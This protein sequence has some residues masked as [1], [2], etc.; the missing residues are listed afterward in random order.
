MRTTF[1]QLLY[2]CLLLCLSSSAVNGQLFINEFMASNGTTLADEAGDFDD[3]IEIYNAGSSAVDL[4]GYYISDAVTN[5]LQ[6]QIPTTNPTLTTV[7]AGGYLLLWADK[8]PTQGPHHINIKLGSGGED[9]VLTAPDGSTVVDQYTYTTQTEDISFGRTSDGGSNWDFFAEPTPDAANTTTPGAPQVEA[10]SISVAGGFKTGSVQVDLA[11]TTSGATIYYTLDGSKPTENSSEYT[12]TISISSSAPLRARAFLAPL[13]PSDITTETYLFNVNHTVPVVAYTADPFD[14]YDPSV[15]MFTN[16]EQDIE[17]NVNAELYE[18]DGTQGFNQRFESEI[19]GTGSASLPQK[20]LVLK[21]KSSLGSST[22]DYQVFPKSSRDKYRSLTLRNSGQDWNITMFRDAM[23]TSLIWDVDDVNATNKTIVKPEIF[24][25]AYRPG[26]T[27]LNGEYW[28]LLNIRE[29]SD[30]RYIRVHFGLDDNEIDF[31]ENLNEV[32][33]GDLTAWTELKDYLRN[34]NLSSESNFRYV[35][36]RVD[37]KHY[38][39]YVTF[40]IYIDNS[41]WPSNN[42]RRFRERVPEGQWRWLTFDLDFSFGLFVDGQ[43]WNSGYNDANSLNRLLT[44]NGFSWPNTESSTLLFRKLME[45]EDWRTNF[46]NRMADQLNVLFNDSRVVGRIN[47]FQADYAPEIQQH[48]DKWASGFQKFDEN[49]QKLRTF[50]NGRADNVRNHFVSEISDITGTS[51][52]T[53]NLNSAGQ[54]E[55]E[56]STISIHQNNAPFTGTYFDG[57]DIPVRAYPNR[58][59]VLQSWSGGLSGNNPTASINISSNTSIT[60]NFGPGSFAQDPIVINEINYNSADFL[61]SDDWVELYNPNNSA[62]DISGWYFE[63]EGGDYFSIPANTILPADGYLV[64]VENA[65]KFTTIYPQVTNYIGDFGSKNSAR[66]FGL[67]GGGERITLK[68][69]GGVLIDE[70]E[71]DDKSPWPTNAD[72]NGPTLQLIAPNLDNALAAS[73]NGIPATPGA[74]NG[75]NTGLNQTINFPAIADKQ[76]TSGPFQISAT[77]TS[78]LPVSFAIVSGPASIS[79]DQITLNGTPGTV[80]VR[81]SQSGD[82]NWN[83]A[84]VVNQSFNVVLVTGGGNY[85]GSK[86]DMPWVEWIAGVELNNLNH[87]SGKTQ[88]SDFTSQFASVDQGATYPITLSAGYSYTA[89][90]EY[91]RVWI[92]Y[93]QDNV[94]DSNTELAYAGVLSGVNDGAGGGS[95]SGS[96]S[97]PGNALTG[98]TRMRVSMQRGAYADPCENFVN[99]EVEDYSIFINSGNN[100][101]VL[102]LSNCPADV[103]ET[104]APGQNSATVSW[105]APSASTTCDPN[106]VSLTQTA[107]PASGSSFTAGTTTTIEYTA[108]D[109]CGNQEVCS[110]TVTVNAPNN[111]SITLSCPSDITATAAAG[112]NGATVNWSDATAS[113]TCPNGGLSVSQTGGAASG[114]FFQ[115]GTYQITYTATDACGNQET[116]SFTVTVNAP[117]NGSITLSCPSDIT[118]AAAAGQNGATVNWSDATASTTC[119]SGGLSVSQT[120]GAASGTFFQVGTYQITYTATDACGNQENCSFSVTVTGGNNNSYCASKGNAPWLEYIA[121]VELSDL[122][123]TSGKSQYSDYTSQIAALSKGA[124]YP[125]TLTAG[126][127]WTSYDEYFRVWIDYNQNGVFEEPSEIAYSGILSGIPNGTGSG[128]LVGSIAVPGSALN[129]TTRMR[130]SMQRDAYASPCETFPTGEVED[131]NVHINGTGNTAVL[132]L[133]NCPNNISLTANQG[134]TSA[135]ATWVSPNATTT[136]DPNTVT[137][138]RTSGPSSGSAF[139]VNTTTTIEYTAT[140]ECGNQEI[141]SF[142]VTVTPSVPNNGEYC[143]AEGITPWLDYIKGVELSSLNNPSGKSKYSDFTNLSTALVPSNTYDL[144]LTTGY[145]WTT[146]DEYWNVWIDYNQNGI[147]ETPAELAFSG[148]QNRPANGTKTAILN[149]QITVPASASLGSTR[150]RVAMKRGAA[151]DPCEAFANGEV[152]DYTIVLTSNFNGNTPQFSIRPQIKMELFPNPSADEVTIIL[153]NDMEIEQIEIFD[154]ST[155]KVLHMQGLTGERKYQFDVRSWREGMYFLHMKLVNGQRIAKRFIVSANY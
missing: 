136:C 95:L 66:G 81:A 88:Y 2:A 150:M 27:Y 22:I 71:Y 32:K 111:G 21:A 132:T 4:G 151:A 120:G 147:F 128:E 73:W 56:L 92:D 26:V 134:A 39:D 107:G 104:A 103:T 135:I 37:L 105:S 126:Y 63:D 114:T 141:C 33:E 109:D 154:I 112:Q 30:K 53:I 83:P 74:L 50:A 86:G 43:S 48:A 59:F 44:P 57:V 58:G 20:S 42:D 23:A 61:D 35:A 75:T 12:G 99:G 100:T 152:E 7:P 1:T 29:R 115:V 68:N 46:I 70:V 84:P 10:P 146:Y 85:C 24:G 28:G 15:G 54:G 130:I 16:Y 8:E 6:W 19:Q 18:T 47:D 76:T 60:A 13:V 9:I 67:S 94:F 31:L 148:V 142:T 119:P 144:T 51:E 129:G 62:V 52:V 5:P 11:T 17:I 45:N 97:I 77:A 108:T 124:T 64:L 106:T 139:D 116:C 149:G 101:G 34:N 110:F 91:F 87:T 69:A 55:V 65:E 143:D 72:G 153:E 98:A 89:Y 155:Q 79:G 140:D 123:H 49:V 138:L 131:Y 93:N 137:L 41:D 96:V 125:I 36:D 3:W 38:I 117:N 113:T 102:T 133:S 40:N 122:L 80:T 145:S 14:L 118:V 90:A 25:Q 78:G 82:A 127:S 121:G